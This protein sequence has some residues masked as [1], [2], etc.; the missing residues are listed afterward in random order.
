MHGG[1]AVIARLHDLG[2]RCSLGGVIRLTRLFCLVGLLASGSPATA[3]DYAGHRMVNLL[4]V[5]SLPADF[6]AF[7]KEA[8]FRER[9]AFLAGEADRWRNTQDL[10]LKHVNSPDHFFDIE[11]LKDY[12]VTWEFLSPFRYTFVQQLARAKHL[13]PERFPEIPVAKNRDRT[14]GLPGFLPWTIME[15]Y[16]KVKAACSYLK[17][18]E[19]LGTPEEIDNARQ[20]LAYLMGVMGHFAGDASQPLHT[21]MHFNGWVKD[22]PN[23]YTTN[24]RFHSWID[25]GYLKKTGGLE[26]EKLKAM[27][28]KGVKLDTIRGRTDYIFPVIIE[29]IREQHKLVEPLYE[30]DKDGRLS[31][32]GENGML[33]KPVLE[34][35]IVAAAGLLADLW[36]TAYQLAP[37]DRYLTSQLNQRKLAEG[38]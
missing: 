15:Y 14:K 17:V 32:E 10:P 7:V 12:D 29:F 4:A 21:T 30:M 19:E 8:K 2:A 9:I 27:T 24:R 35:Q 36:Y 22:N 3:W 31:G 16:S 28:R 33:G 1:R 23:S 13:N 5:D 6:P 25:G 11:H 38:Q 34:K 37:T 26:F 20:N 18:F